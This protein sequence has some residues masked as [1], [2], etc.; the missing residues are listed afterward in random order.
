ML[1]EYFYPRRV[2]E[3]PA[4]HYNYADQHEERGGGGGSTSFE[5]PVFVPP[6]LPE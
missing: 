2:A 6:A 4:C 3:Q 1:R 5:L